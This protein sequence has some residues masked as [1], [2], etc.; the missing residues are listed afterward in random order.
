MKNTSALFLEKIPKK[1]LQEIE[2]WYKISIISLI[3]LLLILSGITA[4]KHYI[5]SS[6]K[7]EYM[8]KK[9]QN[10][11]LDF[12]ENTDSRALFSPELVVQHNKKFLDS[13]DLICSLIPDNIVL[14]SFTYTYTNTFLKG[15]C[16][17]TEIISGYTQELTKNSFYTQ[18]KIIKIEEKEN[19]FI[20]EIMLF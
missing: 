4:H 9:S 3:F 15:S 8:L 17:S 19:S 13:F 12:T 20:F 7:K 1:T 14:S 18:A 16:N 2:L 6:K 5:V 11:D 10:T